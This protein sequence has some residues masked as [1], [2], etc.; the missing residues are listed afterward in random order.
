M[1]YDIGHVTLVSA[2]AASRGH[3][4]HLFTSL[5][6]HDRTE[7][8]GD[9]FV[10][11]CVLMMTQ[12]VLWA[13]LRPGLDCS[14]VAHVVSVFI[15]SHKQ[16]AYVCKFIDPSFLCSWPQVIGVL[17]TLPTGPVFWSVFICVLVR[18]DH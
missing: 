5:Q 4:A 1:W 12:F 17:C 6:P 3:L 7:V 11:T 14:V 8:E 13:V 18:G 15:A 9:W 16:L 10:C 2:L